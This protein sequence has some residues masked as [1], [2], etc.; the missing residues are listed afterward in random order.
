M[1]R[2]KLA[3]VIFFLFSHLIP[4]QP[5]T[6]RYRFGTLLNCAKL[7]WIA[8]ESFS[9]L[10]FFFFGFIFILCAFLSN[11]LDC[12][13]GTARRCECVVCVCVV[14]SEMNF[15]RFGFRQILFL[16]FENNE[17]PPRMETTSARTFAFDLLNVYTEF[18]FFF[19]SEMVRLTRCV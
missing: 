16:N 5:Q 8:C 14:F 13:C 19:A 11:Q 10:W 4:L 6:L 15:T 9:L 2:T 17:S 1:H 3:R 7:F 18:E 12:V